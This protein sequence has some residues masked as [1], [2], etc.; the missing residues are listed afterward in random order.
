MDYRT[1]FKR[2]YTVFTFC[3]LGACLIGGVAVGSAP[4]RATMIPSASGQPPAVG[5]WTSYTRNLLKGITGSEYEA[6][7]NSYFLRNVAAAVW[8]AK[9]DISS[10]GNAF[11]TDPERQ[12]NPQRFGFITRLLA[13]SGADI[14]AWLAVT[15]IPPILV[16]VLGSIALPKIAGGPNDS[17]R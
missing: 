15:I 6:I 5:E 3:W 14:L 9:Q 10:A 1:R 17:P 4:V 12:D 11:I 2:L 13:T 8:E 16:Y 7:R